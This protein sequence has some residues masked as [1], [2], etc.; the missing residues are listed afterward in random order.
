MRVHDTGADG[1]DATPGSG[2]VDLTLKDSLIERATTVGL[3]SWGATVT[4][5]RSLVRE[6]NDDGSGAWGHGIHSENYGTVRANVTVRNSL[7]D[8]NHR[9]GF[10]VVG[11]DALMEGTV[12][13]ATQSKVN[14]G[15]LGAGMVAFHFMGSRASVT[16]RSSLIE[17][18]QGA[19]IAVFAS[20]ATILATAIKGT[21]SLA[22]GFFGHGIDAEPYMGERSNLTVSNSLIEENHEAGISVLA[23][24]ASIEATM[25]R[26][27]LPAGDGLLGVGVSVSDSVTEQ[28]NVTIR[29]SKIEKNHSKGIEVYGSEGV[30]DGVIVRDNMNF[31]IKANVGLDSGQRS[32]VQVRASL[33]ERN[34]DVGIFVVGSDAVM[35]S[36]VVRETQ[37]NG[38]GTGGRGIEAKSDAAAGESADIT[39]RASLIDSAHDTGIF[40]NA[41]NALIEATVVRETQASETGEP[42]RGIN[43]QCA[44]GGRRSNVIMR[45]SLIEKNQ[46]LGVYVAGS[47]ALIES[48]VVRETSGTGSRGIGIEECKP[49]Q[50][51]DVTV[52][53]S[54]V[55]NNEA[56]GIIVIGS[57]AHVESCVVRETKLDVQGLHGRGIQV[58]ANS[59]TGV[60]ANVG[61]S[62]SLIDSNH[63]AGIFVSNSDATVESALVRGTLPNAFEEFG[64]GIVAVS[65][66]KL[67]SDWGTPPPTVA[68]TRTRVENNARAGVANFGGSIALV[69]SELVCHA[70]DMDGEDEAGYPWSFD[71]SH[72][73]Q[74]GCPDPTGSCVAK[75]AGLEPPAPLV[76]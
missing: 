61:V 18:N 23:A 6:T 39:V 20:D 71:G 56:G 25:V 17:Q 9:Y 30:I 74:C 33:I 34:Q 8:R 54:L 60:R 28:A 49:G 65:D 19:G 35:E 75:S 15:E 48:T 64:D 70:F 67:V 52:R 11:S 12:L 27:T 58:Q 2:P 51:A 44:D 14:E 37:P 38:K 4:M 26:N 7:I 43:V 3:S 13:R 55:D 76:Q 46:G 42:G 10:S 22:N 63:E 16:V 32:S 41:S 45:S 31:G 68:I 47:D 40:V 57:D 59:D 24:D 72:D 50:R 1:I 62:A 29:A 53:A 69:S 5:E 66:P 73:N 36:T 21:Q